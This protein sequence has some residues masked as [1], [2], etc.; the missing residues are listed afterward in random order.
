[1]RLKVYC[2][3]VGVNIIRAVVVIQITLV[4]KLVVMATVIE[5]TVDNACKQSIVTPKRKKRNLSSW[6][7]SISKQKR[8]SGEEYIGKVCKLEY[9]LCVVV[10]RRASLDWDKKL[11]MAYIPLF[12]NWE[13]LL[14]IMPA[15]VPARL[16]RALDK[17]KKTSNVG[18]DGRGRHTTRPNKISDDD[19]NRK[20]TLTRFPINLAIK[21]NITR[22]CETY[23]REEVEAGRQP[24]TEYRY[25]YVFNHYFNLSFGMPKTNTCAVCDRL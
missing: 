13:T 3:I 20:N 23:K 11:V 14:C 2:K 25:K 24:V 21:L 15:L 1:M 19:L 5:L 12:G 8:N 18:T 17:K 22:L 9:S 6:K 10:C 7:H 4:A 16:S